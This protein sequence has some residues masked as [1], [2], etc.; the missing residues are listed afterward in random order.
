M[1][2]LIFCLNATVPIFLTMMAGLFFRKI[3]LFNES[4][5]TKMNQFVFK[6]ALPCCCFKIYQEL[7]FMKCGMEGLYF[8]V[9][10]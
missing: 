5:I 9:L 6:V 2:N 4:F 10:L 3:G 1:E 7:I 8:T